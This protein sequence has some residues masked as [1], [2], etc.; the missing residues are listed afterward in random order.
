MWPRRCGARVA[1][2][3]PGA[4]PTTQAEREAQRYRPA[5]V[6]TRE[7]GPP[8]RALRVLGNQAVREAAIL[9]HLVTKPGRPVDSE[10]LQQDVR[11]L[12]ST[13][14]FEDVETFVEQ[15]EGAVVV[16]YQVRERPMI[17][18][19]R[20]VG[21]DR[22]SDKKLLAK[23]EL[24]LGSPLTPYRI[25]EARRRIQDYY[26]ESGYSQA[27]VAIAD[28]QSASGVVTFQV[29]EGPKQ[30]IWQVKFVGNSRDIATDAR[31][32]SIVQSKSALPWWFKSKLDLAKLD[33]DV[34][35]LTDYYRRLGFFHARVSRELQ[36]DEHANWGAVTFVI[37]EGPRY[38]VRDVQIVG[39]RVFRT[40][41]LL[42]GLELAPGGYFDRLKMN[43]DRATLAD[44]YGA[45]GYIFAD[46][47]PDIQFSD[48]P[49]EL[50]L[51]YRINEGDSFYAQ[52]IKVII[53]GDN[54]HTRQRAVMNYLSISPMDRIDIREIRNSKR[55]LG[56]SQ[57]FETNPALGTPPD[58]RVVPAE[59]D[60]YG[61]AA[62]PEGPSLR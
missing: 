13:G 48:Q 56:A 2:W 15:V 46:V 10:V 3:G 50:T 25:E 33:N 22:I 1:A 52:D 28:D 54:P 26:L 34:Q 5:R 7:N 42:A 40:E 16:T 57:I 14:M 35:T 41:D 38:L 18:D 9:Q 58:I 12:M 60:T 21:N 31:L 51:V 27:K 47:Q 61:L 19:L 49:G 20:F 6:Y 32:R 37:D 44:A 59:L 55:R 30:R 29:V 23:S 43:A 45:H 8:V 24:K 4:F 17:R 39:N 53:R 62:E 11:K 36:F